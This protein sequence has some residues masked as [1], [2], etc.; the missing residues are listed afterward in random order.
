MSKTRETLRNKHP[1]SVETLQFQTPL[2]AV[3]LKPPFFFLFFKNYLNLSECDFTNEYIT[4]IASVYTVP[5]QSEG[6]D[7]EQPKSRQL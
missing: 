7:R 5:N 2:S 1:G 6:C 3:I 4:I